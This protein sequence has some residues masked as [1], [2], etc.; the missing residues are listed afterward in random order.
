MT[1]RF[2]TAVAAALGFIA[3]SCAANAQGAPDGGA[4]PPA[5]GPVDNST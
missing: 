4:A 5:P 3:L 2:D 1:F